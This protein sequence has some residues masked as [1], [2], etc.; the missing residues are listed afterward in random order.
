M[1]SNT[2]VPVVWVI[3][4]ATITWCAHPFSAVVT[5]AQFWLSGKSS[6]LVCRALLGFIQGGFIPDL[7]LYLSCEHLLYPHIVD[8][9]SGDRHVVRLLHQDGAAVATGIFLDV[10]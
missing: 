5:I 9:R 1:D 6:F 7:I 2:D 8:I 3:S 4:A 10:I